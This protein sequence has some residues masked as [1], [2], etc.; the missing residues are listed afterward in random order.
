MSSIRYTNGSD[1]DPANSREVSFEF[2]LN[3]ITYLFESNGFFQGLAFDAL[4]VLRDPVSGEALSTGATSIF[5]DYSDAARDLDFSGGDLGD[6]LVSGSGNDSLKG[7][8]GDDILEGGFGTNTIDG[9]AG[10]NTVT[11]RS[12]AVPSGTG[13]FV[14]LRSNFAANH[15]RDVFLSDSLSNIQNIVGSTFQDV[16]YGSSGDNVIEG[17]AFADYIFGRDGTDTASYSGSSAGVTVDLTTNI[18]RGGDAEGDE[19]DGI[20]NLLG[21]AHDDTLTG[22]AGDNTLSG[23]GGNDTLNG[24]GGND[25]LE[26]GLGTN[27]IDGGTGTNTVSYK[28]FVSQGIVGVFVRL[29]DG[30]GVD[31][32]HDG[33][34]SDSLRNIQNIV[35]S[36][37]SDGLIGSEGKNLIEGGAGSDELNGVGGIDTLSYANSASGVAVSLES[38]FGRGG[39]AQGDIF[40]LFENVLGSA[41]GDILVGDAGDNTLNGN[42]GSDRLH[43]LGGDDRLV[44]DATPVL[45]D[46]GEGKD[47]LFVMGGGAIRL[48]DDSFRSIESVYI[49]S[50]TD[51]DLSAVTGGTRIVAQTA[52]GVD[53]VGTSGDDRIQVR[54]GSNTIEGGAGGDKLFGGSGTDT[55]RFEAGFGRDNLYGLDVAVDRIAVAIEGVDAGDVVLRGLKGG[56]DTLVTFTGVETAHRI[57]LHDV[58][59]AD[60]EEARSELFVFGA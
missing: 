33:I 51:L 32:L 7:G 34:L 60:A 56:T 37:S 9:G 54:E 15:F 36:A 57:I 29:S 17:G 27:I 42:G 8:A 19:L 5:A 59:L 48:G 20:E 23:G 49:R 43:G 12:Y 28:N 31:R 4:G 10:T 21:S 26:G 39:D 30:I 25:V 44:I 41:F 16:L 13:V 53:I 14:D 6:I 1:Y 22:D 40:R 45:V 58:A 24:G 3:G 11:Y 55:F 50:D 47:F 18:N 38:G 46:G 2:D 52:F 35:G